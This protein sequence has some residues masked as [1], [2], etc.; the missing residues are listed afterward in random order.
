M[1]GGAPL[2]ERESRDVGRILCGGGPAGDG[3]CAPPA[4]SRHLSNRDC[5][6][7]SRKLDLPGWRLRAMVQPI[8]DLGAWLKIP[9]T[10]RCKKIPMLAEEH[11]SCPWPP[12]RCL[13]F[14]IRRR[15]RFPPL[16]WHHIFSI[17]WLILPTTNTGSRYQLKNTSVTSMSRCS[18]LLPGTTFFRE[19][20]CATTSVSRPTAEVKRHA[21]GS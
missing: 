16:P 6:Q 1:G 14:P 7:Q 4:S 9:S 15:R 3:H 21:K 12:I 5:Q 19:G 17:G 2:F 20:R 8:M 13:I 10:V 11:G 18:P